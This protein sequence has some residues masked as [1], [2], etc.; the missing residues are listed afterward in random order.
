MLHKVSLLDDAVPAYS[1][2][3][4]LALGLSQRRSACYPSFSLT[5]VTKIPS[6]SDSR[7]REIIEHVRAVSEPLD[8]GSNRFS[9]ITSIA[10]CAMAKCNKSHNTSFLDMRRNHLRI[11]CVLLLRIRTL[12][13][14]RVEDAAQW[15][16]DVMEGQQRC[17]SNEVRSSHCEWGP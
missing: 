4:P 13:K 5:H 1:L 2:C 9:R 8:S 11:C 16:I 7:V 14:R 6:A 15:P 12:A 17:E 10:E 3:A